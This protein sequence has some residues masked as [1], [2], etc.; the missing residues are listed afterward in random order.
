L[1]VAVKVVTG[2]VREADVAGMVNPEIVG[3]VVSIITVLGVAKTADT[4]PAASLA[5]GYSVWLPAA[6]AV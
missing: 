1:S 3:A 4:F 6:A 5:Q 2:T